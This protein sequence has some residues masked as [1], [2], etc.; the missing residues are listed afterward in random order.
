MKWVFTPILSIPSSKVE[1]LLHQCHPSLIGGH[2]GITE[3]Y[4]M[5]SD[6]FYCPN[7]AFHL[8]AYITGYHLCQL[9]KNAKRIQ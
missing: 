5:I 9:F 2:N 3:I 6:R 4:T 7:L 8:R 1:L